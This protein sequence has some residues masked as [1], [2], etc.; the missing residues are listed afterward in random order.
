MNGQHKEVKDKFKYLGV[1]LEIL[2][3]GA[4]KRH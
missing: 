3:H 2:G 1:F 4:N